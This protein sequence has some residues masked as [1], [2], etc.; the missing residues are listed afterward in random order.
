MTKPMINSYMQKINKKRFWRLAS[1]EGIVCS[2]SY[3]GIF[4]G[5]ALVPSA[6]AWWRRDQRQFNIAVNDWNIRVS[7]EP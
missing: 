5:H 7:L 6:A 1:A 2:L 4:K 3:M